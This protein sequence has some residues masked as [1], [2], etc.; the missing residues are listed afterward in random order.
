MNVLHTMPPPREREGLHVSVSQVKSYQICPAKYAHHYVRGTLPTHRAV[1]LAFGT[2]VHAALATFYEAQM[3]GRRLTVEEVQAAFSDRW[4]VE[5]RDD[6]PLHFDDG[7][8]ADDVRDQGVAMMEVFCRDGF[9]PDQVLAVELPFRVNL[10]DPD[11]GEI[12]DIALVGA[13]DMVAAHQGRTIVV[14]HKTAA[15][16]FDQTRLTYDF[17]PSA[18]LYAARFLNLPADP[19][20]I[21]QVLLKTKKPAVDVLPVTRNET[22]RMEML[23]TFAQVLKGIE[24]GAFP[25]NRGWACS[26]CEFRRVCDR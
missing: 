4:S 24:A 1:S 10:P 25:R 2:A 18:Y 6:L 11:T 12:L 19:T 15:R 21:F 7:Q 14:E 17:Q 13:I 23:D 9:M 26:D 22:A 5:L 8:S 20:A 3:N 16:R